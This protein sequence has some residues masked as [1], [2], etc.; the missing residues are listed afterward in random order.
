LLAYSNLRREAN[1]KIN[2]LTD[3]EVVE[4]QLVGIGDG[5]FI[6]LVGRPWQRT[7]TYYMILDDMERSFWV[8]LHSA[9]FVYNDDKTLW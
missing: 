6:V 3:N 7:K 9:I 2:W 1:T 5:R 8:K 4:P